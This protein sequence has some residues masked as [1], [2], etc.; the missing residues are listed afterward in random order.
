[1]SALQRLRRS[2]GIGERR[3]EALVEQHAVGEPAQRVVVGQVAAVRLGL[4]ERGDIGDD[5][6][7]QRNPA[8]V[9]QA[10]CG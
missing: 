5:R 3:V 2:I 1:M 4:A 6:D 9:D 8:D 10:S 7:Q